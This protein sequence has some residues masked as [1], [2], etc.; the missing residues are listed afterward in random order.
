[1]IYLR[2]WG[3]CGNQFFQYAFARYI[4]EINNNEP[5]T[6]DFSLCDRLAEEQEDPTWGNQLKDFAIKDV[7][8]FSQKGRNIFKDKMSLLQQLVYFLYKKCVTKQNSCLKKQNQQRK[9]MP[10]MEMFNIYC[11]TD[12]YYPYKNLKK[13]GD[14]FLVGFFESVTYVDKI[15]DR[16]IN[17]YKPRYPLRQENVQLYK[18]IQESESVC[19]SIRRGDFF[20]T[21]GFAICGET[22]FSNAINEIEKHIKEPV[23][24]VFSDDIE[25]VKQNMNFPGKV[26][27]ETGKDP[28][29][30]K[31]RLM[32]GCRHFIISNSTFSWW[33]QY[34]ATNPEKIV[35]APD[36]WNNL[37]MELDIMQKN[38]I[39]VNT[40]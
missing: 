12:G 22:Y 11:Y 21:E 27:F 39:L 37:D 1:M 36:H 34:L 13:K 35:I 16:L 30:E 28:I 31:V 26:Y 17:E 7:I 32:S 3:R 9:W 8:L 23:Y 38:W 20:K 2:I 15:R 33:T 40:N 19:I 6:I 5:I 10:L 18:V 14:K 4:S 25:W 24:I 29:Y